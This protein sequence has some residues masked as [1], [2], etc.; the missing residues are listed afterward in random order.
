MYD[1]V[2]S[3]G[4]VWTTECIAGS[5]YAVN[6]N[7]SRIQYKY[8][9]IWINKY[10]LLAVI[11]FTNKKKFWKFLSMN[12]L[13]FLECKDSEYKSNMRL[14]SVAAETRCN[15][16]YKFMSPYKFAVSW[17]KSYLYKIIVFHYEIRRSCV[18]MGHWLLYSFCR[19]RLIDVDKQHGDRSI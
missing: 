14:L 11:F 3:K 16:F 10:D 8:I 13:H 4:K 5:S 2:Q 15:N 17:I 6:N 9:Q 19:H 18:M 1:I 12:R 7:A